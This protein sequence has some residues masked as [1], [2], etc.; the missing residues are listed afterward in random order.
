MILRDAADRVA[1][2]DTLGREECCHIFGTA[3]C[4]GADTEALADLLRG[5]AQRGETVD[6]IVG[7]AEA[8]RGAMVPF[9][10]GADKAIDTCGTGGDCLGSFNLSTASA[11]VAAAAGAKVVKHGNR[12]V[13]SKCGSADL[14]EVAGVHLELNPEQAKVVFEEVG[15]VF[16]FAPSFHPSMR[17]VAPVRQEL[18]IRTIFNY[19]GP[20][21][22]P[23]RV[24]R[25]LLGVGVAD[26]LE[27][28]AKVLE[29]L[30]A[31]RAYVVHGA[32]GADELTLAGPNRVIAVGSAPA[33]QFDAC[34]LGLSE[35]PVE[36]LEGGDS[37]VNLKILSELLSGEEGPIR[38]AI[39]QNT[40][41][42]LVV[43]EVAQDGLEG[44]ALAREA[45][46]SGRAKSI[47]DGLISVSQRVG[48]AA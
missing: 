2:G 19:L 44:V 37:K 33:P 23:G 29:S 10:H 41:A 30:G 35:S 46:D 34:D 1:L 5:L 18:G 31:Q 13:S 32:G 36:A 24:N 21:C 39:L 15:M 45:L 20:L 28:Y 38:D 25:Q 9:E 43:G 27:D 14:L 42:A 17:F 7:A 6:E 48:G 47:L 4:E 11:L 22:S 26:K 16:L 40:A 3:L 8:L 12:S